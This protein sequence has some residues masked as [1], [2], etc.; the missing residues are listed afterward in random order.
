MKSERLFEAI[1]EI[2]SDLIEDAEK[3]TGHKKRNPKRI[4]LIAAALT[5]LLIGT[6]SAEIQS[7]LVSNL[8]APLYGMA[9]TKIVD[10][11]GIPID[12]STT[13]NGYTLTADAVIGDRYN[14]AIVYTLQR[15]D[16]AILP[17]NIH[18]EDDGNS[19]M[20]AS[21]GGSLYD[22]MSEDGTKKYIVQTWNSELPFLFR[23]NV[24][25]NF[26]NLVVGTDDPEKKELVA[27]G[28]WTLRFNARYKDTTQNIPIQKDLEVTG[29]EGNQYQIHKI[30]I[31]KVG[32]HMNLIAP[33][34]LKKD[35]TI[36]KDFTVSIV[37]QDGTIIEIGNANKGG[38][39]DSD[40]TTFKAHYTA[41]FDEPLPP[42]NIKSIVI[43]DTEIPVNLK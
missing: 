8:L 37:L 1:G 9:Q 18:F 11:I 36:M 14:I 28:T 3:N 6:A 40:A 34:T 32:I 31:S 25:S 29:I 7:G 2:R 19:F 17:A 33:N 13:V 20:W 27:E 42:E 43:C 23:H 4:F 5:A 12:A 26:Y 38:G 24:E 39:G 16:G 21:G 22:E 30:L 15:E 10:D 35:K 41:S